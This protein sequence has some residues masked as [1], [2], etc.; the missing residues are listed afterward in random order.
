MTGFRL[1]QDILRAE[2]QHTEQRLGEMDQATGVGTSKG[3]G[4]VREAGPGHGGGRGGRTRGCNGPR[5]G[6]GPWGR[7]RASGGGDEHGGRGCSALSE[8]GD[9]QRGG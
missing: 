8:E 2:E 6:A 3:V 9:V 4:P 5:G 1:K 7:G